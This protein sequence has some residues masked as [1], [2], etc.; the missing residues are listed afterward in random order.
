MKIGKL[1]NDYYLAMM[2]HEREFSERVYLTLCLVSMPG[3]LIALIA[4]ILTHEDLREIIALAGILILTPSIT[5]ICLYKNNL[6]VA[7]TLIIIGLMLITLPAIFFFGGGIGGGGVIWFIFT[8]MFI[9]LTIKGKRRNIVLSLLILEALAFYAVEYFFPDMIVH[10]SG[11]STFLDSFISI[12][13]VGLVCFFMNLF[14]GN[15]FVDEN[16]R[17]KGEARRAEALNRSQNR[18][19]SSMSHEIRTPINSILGLNELI[20]RDNEASDEIIKDATGI[21]GAGKMLLALIN[22]ILDFSKIEA[23]SMDI[24]PVDYDVAKMLSE[25]VN[26]IWQ[27]AQDKGL[28]VDVGID[29]KVPQVLYG[30]EVRIK[31]IL[32]NLLNNAVKYTHEG[33]VTIHIDCDESDDEEMA[34]LNISVSD[35]GMG[36]KKEVIPY[37]FDAFKRVDEENN[38]HIEGT[39][40]GLNIVKR[41]V[42]LMGGTITV[43][44]VYG[45]GSTFTVVLKQ[46]ISDHTQIGALNIHNY[47]QG[48]RSGYESSF[49]APEAHVLIVDDNEMNLKVEKKLLADTKMGIDTVLSGREALNLC[50]KK[51]FDVILMDHLMPEMDGIQCLE[52]IRSQAGGLNRTTPVIVLTANAGSENRD[53]YNRSGFDGYLVKPVSGEALENMVSKYISPEK[54]IMR[55][56]HMVSGE[57]INTLSGYTKKAP[58]IITTSSV[59]DLPDSIIKKLDIPILPFTIQTEEG[60]FKDSVQLVSD[61]LVRYINSGRTALS[62]APEVEDYTA[63]FAAALKNAHHLIH[64]ALTSSMSEDFIK[65]TAAARSFDN[66]TVI[67]SGVLSTSSGLLVL[68]AYKLAQQGISVENIIAELEDVKKRLQCSFVIDTTEFMA[69]KGHISQRLN[70]IAKSLNMHPSLKIKDDSSGIGAVWLGSTERAY[71]KYIRKALP[72]DVT[73][74]PDVAF[75]TYVDVPEETLLWIREEI[76]KITYF[77]HIVFMKAS[78]AISTNCGPGTFGILY[79]VKS[80]KSY[81]IGS[82]IDDEIETES[83]NNGDNDPDIEATDIGLPDYI[84]EAVDAKDKPD[85]MSGNASQT[86]TASDNVYVPEETEDDSSGDEWYHNIEGIDGD[87]AITNSGSEESFKAILKI[88]YDSIPDKSAELDGYY[89]AE[90]WDNYTIKIHALKSSAKLVGALGL[91]ERA[92]LLE[93][94]G[95]ERNIDYIKKHYKPFMTHYKKYRELLFDYCDDSASEEE[96]DKPVAD[97][98]LMEGVFDAVKE[99]AESM[100]CGTIE[101]TLKELEDYAIPDEY[102]D[103]I[104]SIREMAGKFDYEGIAKLFA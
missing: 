51:K 45:E 93:N 56:K 32:I 64:I 37:L 85:A 52:A 72:A 23:G 30:D 47:T 43:N 83:I 86:E 6:K 71:S 21:Q 94:A 27:K 98:F 41:L 18:F 55:K 16:I 104:A 5:F 40:L 9:G 1:A 100:D 31:Q 29:P 42:T 78:A 24:I 69:R 14:Q 82:Y 49:I 13:V 88:F 76:L 11:L 34:M 97:R 7:I 73:P 89:E 54:L 57:N 80:G 38:R 46:K 103:K 53:L 102:A 91:G 92:Q 8:F 20:L 60:V 65:A 74:D 50:V 19:F 12:V 4:D 90:D 79:F 2:D 17:A 61:E 62:S 26:M 99:A 15:L 75:I 87:T 39:G 77:E 25:I 95:K 28:K 44:S 67:N 22:D 63:F 59:A 81:N 33:T 66:V 84:S 70:S 36:I 58:V 68:I 3:V 96:Q 48:K 10:H 35:T 101:D